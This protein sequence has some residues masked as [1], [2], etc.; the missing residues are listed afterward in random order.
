MSLDSQQIEE[1]AKRY[2]N[3][4]DSILLH[5]LADDA[6]AP[7]TQAVRVEPRGLTVVP[8]QRELVLAEPGSRSLIRATLSMP[9]LALRRIAAHPRESFVTA[10]C[11]M[12]IGLGGYQVGSWKE[13]DLPPNGV[14]GS[15]ARP[16]LLDAPF[17]PEEA[18]NR[19]TEWAIYLGKPERWSNSI[20]QRFAL[21]PP[22]EFTMGSLAHQPGS[23]AD[24]T[25][26]RVR[27]SHPLYASI[28]EVT[29]GQFA[30]VMGYNPASFRGSAETDLPVESL[31]WFEMI[32]FCNR[33]SVRE[34]LKEYYELKVTQRDNVRIQSGIVGIVGEDGYRLPTEAEWEY[35]CRAGTTTLFHTGDL[36]PGPEAARTRVGPQATSLRPSPVGQSQPNAFELYDLHG[37]VFEWVYDWYD[38]EFYRASPRRDPEGPT[39][40]SL[41]VIRGG[42]FNEPPVNA[43]SANRGKVRPE[44]TDTDRG[45]R[46]VRTV[47]KE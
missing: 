27:I 34:G 43:R 23:Q 38:S 4:D 7:A 25:E 40:G 26:H 32:E 29:Q 28:C 45:F 36:D 24:E 15:L 14:L 17:S 46:V 3:P 5:L 1:R 22:G 33:L 39:H 12:M 16:P 47:W 30:S 2:L 11:A 37:N 44:T 13:V 9:V 42:S 21:I 31:T 10:A 19:R 18:R 35:L 6:P 8:Q 20:G 41:R